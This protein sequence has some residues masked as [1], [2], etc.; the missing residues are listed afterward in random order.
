MAKLNSIKSDLKKSTKG[1]ECNYFGITLRIA[2]LNN[3]EFD[4]CYSALMEPCMRRGRIVDKENADIAF[5]KAIAAH[6]LVG[7][8]NL[9][10][11]DG[12][13]IKYSPEKA[14]EIISDTE[15]ADLYLFVVE[16]AREEE[17]Y[18]QEAKEEQVKNLPT[19]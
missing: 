8:S 4:K 14:F 9:D 2:S 13:P 7:W 17:A 6:V 15:C 19:P 18:R 16:K 1:V 10:G 5:K 12:K 11:D 3:P